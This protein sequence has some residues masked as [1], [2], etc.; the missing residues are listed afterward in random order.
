ME[1]PAQAPTGV[2]AGPSQRSS[3]CQTRRAPWPLCGLHAPFLSSPR[4]TQALEG[5]VP[6]LP[7][8]GGLPLRLGKAVAWGSRVASVALLPHVPQGM[9]KTWGALTG[10]S[11]S[12]R[13][14]ARPPNHNYAWPPQGP[15]LSWSSGPS[16]GCTPAP[17]KAPPPGPF[18][19]PNPVET[20]QEGVRRMWTTDRETSSGAHLACVLFHPHQTWGR[21]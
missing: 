14:R 13:T 21:D 20:E 1:A 11:S 6:H 4:A 3:P 7:T 2:S 17:G 5:P 16:P 12:L 18:P 15:P 10:P 19:F 8:P 9:G